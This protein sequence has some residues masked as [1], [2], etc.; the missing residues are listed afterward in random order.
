MPAAMTPTESATTYDAIV[1]PSTWICARAL[2]PIPGTANAMMPGRHP[3]RAHTRST[4]AANSIVAVTVHGQGAP[5]GGGASRTTT[6]ASTNMSVPTSGARRAT[7]S[8]AHRTA[9]TNS[10]TSTGAP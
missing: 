8:A 6:L 4:S 3:C 1:L 2:I 10:A 9:V 5:D 7:T